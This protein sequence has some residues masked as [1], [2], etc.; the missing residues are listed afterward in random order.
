MNSATV[1]EDRLGRKVSF[2]VTRQVWESKLEHIRCSTV[3][4]FERMKCSGSE[5]PGKTRDSGVVGQE[6]EILECQ[7]SEQGGEDAFLRCGDIDLAVEVLCRGGVICDGGRD[8]V[9][10]NFIGIVVHRKC[11]D[12]VVVLRILTQE[13]LV[14]GR[15]G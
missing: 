15:Q 10:C 8:W 4:V 6:E 12:D 2:C 5:I 11:F 13:L 7:S 3:L 9:G 14:I 1:S